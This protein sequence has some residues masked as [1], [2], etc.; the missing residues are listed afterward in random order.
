MGWCGVEWSGSRQGQ[1]D[2]SCERV[3]E[4]SGSINCW[5]LLSAC[6][7]GGVSSAQLTFI[8]HKTYWPMDE[9]LQVNDKKK[10]KKERKK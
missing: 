1:V 7:T 10:K 4:P 5:E 6:T 3:N 2:S 8:A 9:K